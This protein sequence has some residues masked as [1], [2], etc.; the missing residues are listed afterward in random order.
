M[1]DLKM[2]VVDLH[3]SKAYRDPAKADVFRKL[4]KPLQITR[5][6]ADSI[7]KR[8]ARDAQPARDAGSSQ[9]TRRPY[10]AKPRGFRVNAAYIAKV[11]AA[12]AP[13]RPAG[14]YE[15]SAQF[16]KLAGIRPGSY[17]GSGGMWQGMY[18]RNWGGKGAIIDFRGRS[19]GRRIR[20]TKSREEVDKLKRERL[21]QLQ[22][23]R[24]KRGQLTAATKRKIEEIKDGTFAAKYKRPAV[25]PNR[26]KAASI[27]KAH[28]LNVLA[29]DAA[30]LRTMEAAFVNV[31]LRSVAELFGQDPRKIP[32]T[33]QRNRELFAA[34]LTAFKGG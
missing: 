29:P 7:R 33:Q 6:L 15:S 30:E 8:V 18:V 20:W 31:G 9:H 14:S 26:L 10:E 32:T 16:H 5:A 25:V 23:K 19:L 3:V 24:N 27:F 21:A 34:L 4:Q 28:R 13:D 12:A 11:A 1:I 17:W 22:T 2:E